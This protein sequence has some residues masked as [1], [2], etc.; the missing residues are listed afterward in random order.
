MNNRIGIP[1][2]T[3]WFV[4]VGSL[5][6]ISVV[7]LAENNTATVERVGNDIEYLASDEL[8]GRGPT[9][10]GLQVAAEYIRDQFKEVGLVSGTEDGSFMQPFDITV[11]TEPVKGKTWL[12]LK[13]PE[14]QELKLEAG[15]DFQP[16]ATG[17]SGSAKADVI[18]I[19]YGISAEDKK[20]DDYQNIDVKDKVVLMIRREPQQ[21]DEES[22]FDGKNV[23]SHSYIRT[24]LQVAKQNEAAAILMVND[25][26][27]TEQ[28]KEDQLSKPD[29]FGTNGIDMP[30]AHLK[31]AVADQLL[32][33]TPV[34][35][36]DGEKLNSIAAI[37]K[38]INETL[39]PMSQPLEGW[40][41]ELEFE[42]EQVTA[43]IANVVGVLEGAGP[44]ANE[45]VVIGAHYDHLGYGPFGSR[46]PGV[47][48]IH[49]G[50]D[51]NATGTAAVM[52][53]ARRFAN[54][55]EKPARRMVFIGFTGEERGLLG[56]NYYVAN[57][58]IPLE[59][60][61]A[62]INFDM[63]GNLGDNGLQVGGVRTGKE[64]AAIVETVISQGS[65][66]V[67]TSMPMGGSDHAGFYRKGIPVVF[68][69]TGLTDLYHT[70]D[71][72]FELINVEGVVKTIDFAEQ[73]LDEVVSM[74]QRPEHVE[75]VGRRPPRRGA[76]AYIGIVPDYSEN[77]GGLRLT[78][79]TEGGPA[80]DAGLKADDII[81]KIGDTSVADIQ[82]L[83]GGL[84][85][86]RPGQKVD[87]VV[88]R[89][90]EELTLEVTLG[91]PPRPNGR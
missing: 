68:F 45:T 66:K 75:G 55:D 69:H 21:G 30:M 76:M 52:E 13:G 10:K 88:K 40:T 64:F 79:V 6:G 90:D 42:F 12:I 89:G 23:T 22:V 15:K 82:G 86:Y 7:S 27:S 36:A 2:L 39:A 4:V 70:P 19:G 47:K 81:T 16:L 14:G 73:F 67:N 9:T 46:R 85:K 49:N 63:I 43:G 38:S 26:F 50:A 87:I 28:A 31:Q 53:L 41:A 60:T 77:D 61:A 33:D 51:D 29:G 24:K 80:A 35:T 62:M 17:G 58:L 18:F 72:D 59:D 11:G 37:E 1:S 74:P 8:E 91:R 83:T 48:A 20:Y 34:K 71:D 32:G 56:S 3:R 54:R 25:P 5:F 78:E 44:L 57:P 84:R 65:L